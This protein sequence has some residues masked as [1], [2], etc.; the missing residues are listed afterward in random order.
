VSN[1]S[2]VRT[3]VRASLLLSTV[4][5]F[6]SALAIAGGLPR[7]LPPQPLADA[8]DDF[9]KMT[10][11]QLV[12]RAELAVGLSSH[13]VQAGASAEEALQ[14]LLQDTGLTYVYVNERTISIRRMDATNKPAREKA[15]TG[16]RL[17]EPAEL[18]FWNRL[19]LAQASDVAEP[20]AE[21]SVDASKPTASSVDEVVV[22]G[23]H[24]RGVTPAA[25]LI[26]LDR[27]AI[28]AT[29]YTAVG[30]VIRTIPQNYGGGSNPALMTNSAPNQLQQPS[31]G[32]APNLF[33][34][35][36][37][38]TL[39]LVN[40]RR[41][42]EGNGGAVDITPI[43]LEV[44]ERIEVVPD[45]SSA[46]YGSDAVAGV[47]N[48]ILKQDFDGAVTSGIV[49][50]ATQGGAF[51]T[52]F[53]QLVGTSWQGGGVIFDY[54]YSHQGDVQSD[55]RDF[56]LEAP[57]PDT[58]LPAS[59]RN[60][61]FGSAHQDISAAV[62]VFAEGYYTDRWVRSQITSYVGATPY[63]TTA[64]VKQHYVTI[65]AN[66]DF[67]ESWH[68]T[69]FATDSKHSTDQLQVPIDFEYAYS[70][71]SRTFEAN[72]D[73]AL[74]TL[75]TG[76]ARLAVGGGHR[77]D[78]YY[79]DATADGDRTVSYAFG[80]LHVPL[81]TPMSRPGLNRLDLSVSGRFEHYSDF[82]DST[83]PKVGLVYEP[84]SDLTLR[85]SWGRSFHAP[86]LDDT[87]AP[88]FLVMNRLP[89]DQ[90]A[91]GT[92]YNLIRLIGNP[93]LDPQTARTWSA[94]LD[95]SPSALPPLHMALGYF[96]IR[97]SHVIKNLASYRTA[98]VNPAD[99][100][101]VTRNPSTEL[102][103]EVLNN[104]GTFINYTGLPYDP[105][106]IA[107]IVDARPN[108]A[109]YQNASGVNASVEYSTALGNGTLT[110]FVNG[111]YL[112]LRQRLTSASPVEEL[113]GTVFAPPHVRARLGAT[114]M[115]GSW[116]FT[117]AA[118]YVGG[119]D[120]IY[121]PSAPHVSSWTTLDAQMAYESP[122]DGA[123][124]RFSVVLSGQ[125]ILDRDPP[126]VLF[127]SG[128]PGLNYDSTNASPL[129]RFVS[130]KL[131]KSF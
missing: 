98:L 48:I 78:T 59:N 127:T 128:Y 89:D 123:L 36:P 106:L 13:G 42:P 2:L 25:S 85:G 11:I 68:G 21:E 107:A 124:G 7:A 56:T 110:S 120:N 30:D 33:G 8:L 87:L 72:A 102:Q 9:A 84:T 67:S 129:G 79:Q 130:L 116:S 54:S 57:R 18:T 90:S 77:R 69:L 115:L 109:A 118:N 12:Y 121:E 44:I 47:V 108:N 70:G 35:G 4:A 95:Y 40:G 62:S 15:S 126:F 58:L 99:A 55:Q 45:G 112:K 28:Q 93:D 125:N 43:P 50:G 34:L 5:V 27:Q 60:S 32:S 113:A 91:T 103:Q 41:L 52:G 10:G 65:G 16:A 100:P 101:L 96:S 64:Q 76:V 86:L 81:V 26:V 73:G 24:I 80:E 119:S 74:L 105:S 29:G 104:A 63:T 19:R 3:F 88:E 114:W 20:R 61:F 122:G 94:G 46:V 22:T 38:S 1:R 53:S 51:E 66:L 117:G 82:G 131:T 14:N 97:Y 31:G 83:V 75:P 17:P 6:N 71:E 37:T 23:S 92:S 111:M 39:T 49:G